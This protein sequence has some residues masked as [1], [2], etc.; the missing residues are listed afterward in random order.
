MII[1]IDKIE[2]SNSEIF[3]DNNIDNPKTIDIDKCE[4]DEMNKK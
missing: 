3:S 4:I 1:N 2:P